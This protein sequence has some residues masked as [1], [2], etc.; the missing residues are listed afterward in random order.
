[1]IDVLYKIE[2]EKGDQS[3]FGKYFFIYLHISKKQSYKSLL[4]LP[5]S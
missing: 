4:L 2:K 3:I 5:I 1:M